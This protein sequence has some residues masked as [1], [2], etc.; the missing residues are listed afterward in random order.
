M[1]GIENHR[2]PGRRSAR[3]RLSDAQQRLQ[4]EMD[5]VREMNQGPWDWAVGLVPGAVSADLR[6]D[7]GDGAS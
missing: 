7:S 5:M 3:A 4:A 6:D 2:R 1:A